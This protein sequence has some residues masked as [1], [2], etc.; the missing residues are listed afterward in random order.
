MATINR[1]LKVKAWPD[2]DL[3]GPEHFELVEAPVPVPRDAEVLIR[4]LWLSIDPYYRQSLG[5]RFVG[6]P[7]CHPGSVMMA[8]SLGRVLK[9][10]DPR[11]PVGA[12]VTTLF[13]GMQD[14]VTV[15]G[16]DVRVLPDDLFGEGT[17]KL[18]LSTALGVAG[19]PGL[20]AWAGLLHHAR[21]QLGETFVVSSASGPVGATAG[22]LARLMGL[23]TVGIAGTDAK[24]AW[25]VQ[26]A[27]FDAC[28]S[29]RSPQFA[30]ELAAACPGGIDINFEHVGGNV[31]ATVLPLMRDD[32]RVVMCGMI[33]Q[34]NEAVAPPGPNWG[35]ILQKRLTVSGLRVFEHFA[36][37][38]RFERMI[39]P[40]LLDGR[41]AFRED[42]LEDLAQAPLSLARVLTGRNF[43]KSLIRIAADA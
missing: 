9:S 27:R 42:V 13:G 7:F 5:P 18:P 22:Q 32:G 21:P 39:A 10:H 15:H 35:V 26:A 14:Y 4:N 33:D 41:V 20:T 16:R 43:G 19:I 31:L 3:P 40:M 28:V 37:M 17:G 36:L 12:F 38:P 24:L 1:Q 25:T 8:V 30:A 2:D 29:Y 11:V 34:Y 6:V 23:R